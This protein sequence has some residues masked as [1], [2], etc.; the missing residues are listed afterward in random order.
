MNFRILGYMAPE[1][2]DNEKYAFSPDWFSFGCLIYE[3]IEGQAPFRA[4]KEKVKREE[5]DRR[6]KEDVE[7]YSTKFSEDAKSLCQQLLIKS[8]KSRLGCRN[9]RQGAKEV[10]V[11]TFFDSTNWKRLEAGM[12]EPPFIPDVRTIL[13][14]TLSTK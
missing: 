1:V 8:S 3:M 7:K 11:H 12:V 2:I 6:V 13:M 5:V 14:A 10:K 9:G 4:R